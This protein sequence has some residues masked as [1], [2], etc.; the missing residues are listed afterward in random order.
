MELRQIQKSDYNLI[1]ELD[2]KVYPVSE[3]NKINFSI[4]DNW[5]NK[6]P[7]YGMIYI[8]TKDNNNNN[9][10]IALAIIIPMPISIWYK[11][12]KGEYFENNL[13]I[14][15]DNINNN[16][17][18]DIGVH[19]YHIEVLNRNIVGKEFYKIMLKDLSQISKNYCHNI[20][21]LS[22]YCVTI[23]G[24]RLFKEILKCKNA[25]DIKDK[26][27]NENKSEFIVEN[28][29]TGKIKIV[30]LPRNTDINKNYL[31]KDDNKNIN[32]EYKFISK[33]NMLYTIKN[34][35]NNEID[36]DNDNI[37]LVWD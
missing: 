28:I 35:E 12:I 25:D 6:Y 31:D 10:I 27:N 21:G 30:E 23:K 18:I 14:N 19:I 36:K 29:N 4:I 1:L 16:K 17:Y 2:A 33:C 11:L 9:N 26:I 7:K 3:E 22:G 5:Y 13:N 15:W 32:N 20:Q 34:K 24:N 8:D 37:S